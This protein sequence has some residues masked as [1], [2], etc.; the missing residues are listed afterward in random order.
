MVRCNPLV[1]SLVVSPQYRLIE[2]HGR[3]AV[4][5]ARVVFPDILRYHLRKVR[6]SDLSLEHVSS[7]ILRNVRSNVIWQGRQRGPDFFIQLF[8]IMSR[9]NFGREISSASSS[10]RPFPRLSLLQTHFGMPAALA[11]FRH[12]RRNLTTA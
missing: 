2:R 11:T 4:V 12:I 10:L 9:V 5:I 3:E 7:Q 1:P 8:A 6:H